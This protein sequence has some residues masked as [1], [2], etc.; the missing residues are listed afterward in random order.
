MDDENKSSSSIPE[1]NEDT[2]SKSYTSDN[3]LPNQTE[4][5]PSNV[6]RNQSE[7]DCCTVQETSVQEYDEPVDKVSNAVE[8][9]D[10]E[11]RVAESTGHIS[12]LCLYFLFNLV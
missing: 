8:A 4:I 12:S 11:G 9:I 6:L 3:L 5:V 10:L 7:N 2:K 1:K